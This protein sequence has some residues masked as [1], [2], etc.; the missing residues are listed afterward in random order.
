MNPGRLTSTMTSPQPQLHAVHELR[1][2]IGGG[3]HGRRVR[4]DV[5]RRPDDDVAEVERPGL[6]P[7]VT[8]AM[9][10]GP[11]APFLSRGR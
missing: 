6:R 5:D 1:Q 8:T 2:G 3:R 10:N 11:V 4:I 7:R 9:P